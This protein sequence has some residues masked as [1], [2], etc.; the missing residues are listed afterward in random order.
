MYEKKLFG[1]RRRNVHGLP[2]FT[3]HPDSN[4][5]SLMPCHN[6]YFS[7]CVKYS[8]DCT[9]VLCAF[10]VSTLLFL[11]LQYCVQTRDLSLKRCDLGATL[12][13]NCVALSDWLKTLLS[14]HSL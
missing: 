12:R 4:K 3:P 10:S 5:V 14:V 8:I 2:V 6:R 7:A 13:S 9:P 11:Y 1:L